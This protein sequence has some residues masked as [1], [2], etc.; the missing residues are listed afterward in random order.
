MALVGFE[1]VLR[2]VRAHCA[3]IYERVMYGVKPLR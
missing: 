1:D 2:F 3:G